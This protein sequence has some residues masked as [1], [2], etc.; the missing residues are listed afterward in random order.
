MR[1]FSTSQQKIISTH[2]GL[3]EIESGTAE[4]IA[5]AIIK[6][7]GDSNLDS[8]N[9]LGIGVDNASVNTGR[10]NGVVEILKKKLDRNDL[11]MVRCACH[12]IQLAVS[13]ACAEA[14]PRN[15]DFIVKETYNWFSQ[16]AKRQAA[17]S[18]LYNHMYEGKQSLK[19]T[20]VCDTRWL[21]IEPAVS[22][23]LSQ[24]NALLSHFQ[25]ARLNEECYTAEVLFNM[26]S[27]PINKLYMLFLR[28]ILT[29]LNRV[30]KSFQSDDTDP[31]K[32]LADLG[33]LIEST[34][35]RIVVPTARV[36]F[37]SDIS[38]HV[39]RSAYLGYEFEQTVMNGQFQDERV[40]IV[41]ERCT[42]LL[43][44]LHRE[45]R[46]RLPD[47]FNV[48]KQMSSF[49]V[50]ICLNQVKNR[51]PNIAEALSYTVEEIENIEVE[52]NNLSLIKWKN[53]TST[54]DFWIE[55]SADKDA[56]GNNPFIH[57]SSLAIAPL[58]C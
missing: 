24:W 6:L 19:I 15:V 36:D 1:Y 23:I 48:L 51:I 32:L 27:D 53:T 30:M 11:I 20:R 55:V 40:K 17:Y 39:D 13:H 8:R 29:E 56:A 52:G 33:T 16:S 7:I 14:L 35:K 45:L 44:A 54:T 10:N 46:H 18:D 21:S 22:R 38:S 34:A 50:N 42:N 12:S 28:P 9:L 4:S 41:R 26:S 57:I 25:S 5:D 49:S 31:T 2:L 43:L 37:Y 58:K 3:L 47:N